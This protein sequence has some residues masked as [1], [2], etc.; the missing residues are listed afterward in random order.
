[1]AELNWEDVP[2]GPV[3]GM[4]VS[5]E[6]ERNKS[7]Q[8]LAM[9]RDKAYARVAE[10][11]QFQKIGDD[12]N[13]QINNFPTSRFKY[14]AAKFQEDARI[15]GRSMGSVQSP[16]EGQD[17]N[18]LWQDVEPEWQDAEP[19]V[20]RSDAEVLANLPE[21]LRF[22]F[23]DTG[24]PL[25]KEV[26]STLVGAGHLM[27]DTYRGVKQIMGIDEE[28]LAYEAQLMTDLY[29]SSEG[30]YAMGGAVIGGVLEP[31]GLLL[32]GMKA[33]S[34]GKAVIK[35]TGIGASYASLGYVNEEAG[36][37]RLGNTAMGAGLGVVVGASFKKISNLMEARKV[38]EA[39]QFLSGFERHWAEQMV[40][41][42]A[43][44][45]ISKE[46]K[47]V[48]PNVSEELTN[49]V[50]LTGRK[51]K[52]SMTTKEA[53]ELLDWHNPT[54]P[55]VKPGGLMEKIGGIVSTRVK[56]IDE[57]VFGTLRQHDYNVLVRTHENLE[58]VNVFMRDYTKKI[59]ETDRKTV[60]QALFNGDFDSVESVLKRHG[61]SEL[62]QEFSRVKKV[63]NDF[64]DEFV[65]ANR[66][67]EKLDNYFPRYVK[68][69][70]GLKAKLGSKK[71]TLLEDA[72]AK[73]ND[74][75]VKKRGRPM[76]PTEEGALI[77]KT[78]RGFPVKGFK[79]GLAKK[80]KIDQLDDEMM[81]F[82]ASPTESLNTYV[83]NAVHD[84]EKLKFFGKD[85]KYTKVDGVKTLDIDAS[86]GAVVQKLK[87][88]LT[89]TQETELKHLLETRFGIG[90]KATSRGMQDV[91]NIMYSGLLANPI[92]AA[93][94]LGDIGVS[95]YMNGFRNTISGLF[96]RRV[97]MEDFGL[98]DNLA[99][100]FATTTK[101]GKFLR[102]SLKWGGFRAIDKL[103]KDTLL[104]S[105]LRKWEKAAQSTKGMKKFDAKYRKVFGDEFEQLALDVKSGKMS[106]NVKL[107]LFNEL[108][109]IQPISLSEMPEMY[110]KM[111]NGR[112]MYML[113]SFM[114]KQ[115]DLIRRDG[116]QEIKKGNYKKGTANMMRY[117][118]TLGAANTGSSYIK[119]AMM[120]K[121]VE[122][123]GMDVPMNFLKMFALSEYVGNKVADGNVLEAG[124]GMLTPPY[125]MFDDI[126]SAGV[127]A[128][129]EEGIDEA[130]NTEW[131]RYMPIGGRLWYMWFGGGLEAAA[132]KKSNKEWE[133]FNE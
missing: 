49:V 26:A 76:N 68:D 80:R 130:R 77:N 121:E 15:D 65:V 118:L 50:N 2:E 81:E 112:V 24:I 132:E 98:A 66:F 30:G 48:Y 110:L 97:R 34:M 87:G 99:E 23:W 44:T 101:T 42:K 43:P 11:P 60:D 72:I 119:D 127:K 40:Q 128:L 52:L 74:K 58:E 37:T 19:L 131:M 111:P 88:K 113:K 4:D 75:L 108:A 79:P 46:L 126:M 103:G 1:M 92:S 85:R 39:E 84:L 25:N 59:P 95:V 31:T 115:M 114:L 86:V 32:P 14:D 91:K 12:L 18:L 125:S 83:R 70:E 93:T 69:F 16:I 55:K 117:A 8:L 51:A 38:N 7:L 64:G 94:Q 29:E 78:L 109:D 5:F 106:E 67:N 36:Q 96:K 13:E 90:E 10:E 116:I 133:D 28:A 104:N 89:G 22:A 54:T 63:L 100:E 3:E 41:G 102:G 124:I 47:M 6:L 21:T 57:G 62:V 123:E 129:E 20:E 56:N 71:A 122:P 33:A 35:G 73:A 9:T 27:G 17:D 45:Q 105:S 61:G 107:M 53:E 120:G 82:Y